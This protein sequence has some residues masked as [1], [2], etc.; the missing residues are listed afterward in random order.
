ML[1]GNLIAPAVDNLIHPLDGQ[2][3]RCVD[4]LETF[5]LS[6]ALT[7]EVVAFFFGNMFFG[8]ELLRE[9]DTPIEAVK[10]PIDGEIQSG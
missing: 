2:A 10:Q 3:E 9:R 6:V 1:S 8:D 7:D 5:A 4:R